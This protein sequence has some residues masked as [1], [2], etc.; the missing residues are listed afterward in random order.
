[1]NSLNN[2]FTHYTK[3]G[4]DFKSNRLARIKS[5]A[6]AFKQKAKEQSAQR[7]QLRK[8]EGYLRLNT[9]D[10]CDSRGNSPINA[11][12]ANIDLESRGEEDEASVPASAKS[13]RRFSR[14]LNKFT[15]SSKTLKEEKVEVNNMKTPLLGSSK[16][17]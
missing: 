10:S 6:A 15:Q 11:A 7:N 2:P 4:A 14:S 16:A 3:S 13:V 9:V 12:S 1:M 17:V 5:I 8:G